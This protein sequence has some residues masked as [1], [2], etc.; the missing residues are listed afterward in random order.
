MGKITKLLIQAPSPETKNVQLSRL[1][2]ALKV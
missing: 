1:I 2:H